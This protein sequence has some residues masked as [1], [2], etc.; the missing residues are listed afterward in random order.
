VVRRQP[1]DEL[2]RV[3]LDGECEAVCDI[4][5]V[6]GGIGFLPNGNVV[7]TSMFDHKLLTFANGKV[8]TLCDL[9]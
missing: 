4:P 2:L 3:S 5:G 7:I 8:S 1:R 6:A 9:C